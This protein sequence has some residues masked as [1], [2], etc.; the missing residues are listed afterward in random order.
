MD[1]LHPTAR[2]DDLVISEM[3][4]ELLV[5]DK[6]VHGMHHL[7][8]LASSIWRNC[9][10]INDLHTIQAICSVTEAET[11]SLDDVVAGL[12]ILA[13]LDLMQDWAQVSDGSRERS[14]RRKILKRTTV[15]GAAIASVTAPLAT[16]HA[17][18]GTP[19][20]VPNGGNCTSAQDCVNPGVGCFP[21]VKGA[22]PTCG[23]I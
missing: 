8:P 11:L 18:N 17:S 5:Y 9:D 7:N 4:D 22:T 13:N 19:G 3:D 20:K 1:G 21:S 16:A 12:N 6:R 2:V 15:A 23:G 14:S 10:G